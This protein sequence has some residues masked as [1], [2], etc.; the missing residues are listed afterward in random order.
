MMEDQNRDMGAG[1]EPDPRM[2]IRYVRDLPT[3]RKIGQER[4][5]GMPLY[6]LSAVGREA[7]QR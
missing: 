6:R 2:G 4:T 7:K 5:D 1:S 3:L